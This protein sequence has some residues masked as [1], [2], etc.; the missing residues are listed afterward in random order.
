M[1]MIPGLRVPPELQIGSPEVLEEYVRARIAQLISTFS[2]SLQLHSPAITQ[3]LIAKSLG[4]ALSAIPPPVYDI[5]P[6]ENRDLQLVF[7]HDCMALG[8]LDPQCSL[9]QHNPSRRCVVNFDRKYL[10]HDMLKARCGASIRI[11][12]IDRNTGLPI[13]EDIPDLRLETYILDGNLYDNKFLEGG[14]RVTEGGTESVED[15]EMC[16]LLLNKKKSTPLLICG[17]GGTNDHQGKV[18][19]PMSRGRVNL[20]EMHV[21]DSSEAILSGRKPPFRLLVR[22]LLPIDRPQ[23][24]I[25]H[26]I[27]EGFV[28]ATRR[29]RTAGKVDIPS[30]ED[31]VSKLEHMGKE[32]VKK[33]ADI[34]AA[35][36]QVG[37]EIDIPENCIQRVGDFKLLALRA[38]QDGHLRQRLQHVL[39][40]SREKWEEARDHAMRAVVG[41]G[42]MRAWY[43]DR[44]SMDA[45]LLF[46]CRLGS[47]E[48]DRPVALLQTIDDEGEA[49]VEATL[50][51]NLTP[52]QR[53]LVRQMQPEAAQGWWMPGHPGWAI[54]P[55]ESESF[56]QT[57]SVIPILSLSD[58]GSPNSLLRAPSPSNPSTVMPRH[59]IYSSGSPPEFRPPSANGIAAGG[60]MMMSGGGGGGGGGGGFEGGGPRSSGSS[61]AAAAGGQQYGNNGMASFGGPFAGGAGFVGQQ[62][63]GSVAARLMQ[64]QGA[65][66]PRQALGT[67][68]SPG[69][70]PNNRA[71][72]LG[73]VEGRPVLVAAAARQHSAVPAMAYP[74]GM[75]PGQQIGGRQ[76]SSA[77]AGL[78]PLVGPAF[79]GSQVNQG[80]QDATGKALNPFGDF[81]QGPGGN[82]QAQ[83]Q[84]LQQQQ[85]HR[86][87]T[88]PSALHNP[89]SAYNNGVPRSGLG[90]MF[91]NQQQQ[92]R[93]SSTG[94]S[95]GSTSY[96][97]SSQGGA[98][99]SQHQQLNSKRPLEPTDSGQFAENARRDLTVP[100]SMALTRQPQPQ[101]QQQLSN[102]YAEQSQ[103]YTQQTQQYTQQN[104]HPAT[105][106]FAA[107]AAVAAAAH[108]STSDSPPSPESSDPNPFL[109]IQ[110]RALSAQQQQR[111]GTAAAATVPDQGPTAPSLDLGSLVS[112]SL[113]PNLFSS[114][115]SLGL[116]MRP[117]KGNMTAEAEKQQQQQQQQVSLQ[118]QKHQQQQQGHG[119]AD[120]T[121]TSNGG[122]HHGGGM[123][124]KS[125]NSLA[126][127]FP[128]SGELEGLDQMDINNSLQFTGSLLQGMLSS[129]NLNA[130]MQ[131]ATLQL[132]AGN[133][134]QQQQ[135]VQ[136][137][138]GQGH[139]PAAMA[140]AAASD[141]VSVQPAAPTGSG[142]TSGSAA[143]QKLQGRN[144]ALDSMQSIEQALSDVQHHG[145]GGHSQPEQRGT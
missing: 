86:R 45:G 35:A 112:V 87:A 88:E 84:Y 107:A 82:P 130:A 19:V 32:T 72:G 8:C 6:L 29:T 104:Q 33:L 63:N 144:S 95:P 75:V 96:P 85:Q 24:Q 37:I 93:P 125:L 43:A 4:E 120:V 55:M 54:F 140:A 11:E 73:A 70:L 126:L 127:S 94:P 114:E 18:I 25:R 134:Q 53:E 111:V 100:P 121:L 81:A 7:R 13:E 123:D 23:L 109:Y 139:G 46:T 57:G 14:S 1:A 60:M 77:A 41:D 12:L 106:G 108:L 66:S 102:S 79:T 76:A 28:V 74:V 42:R 2:R 122:G 105:A 80:Y 89:G 71:S 38:E 113:D 69:L 5:I 90:H 118:Q 51:A 92:K 64:Q 117:P 9:C 67:F 20:P 59:S 15:L 128:M 49:R 16:A 65:G 27:S 145:G 52:V 78:P 30:I 124:L 17:S 58:V 142:G 44:R 40:L 91:G 110:H 56:L 135:Q 50:M 61:G 31:H 10:V 48:L 137:A 3:D 138:S 22:A 129:H 47:V 21:S 68:S 97:F 39:K 26:A 132:G 131:A 141:G 103:Q 34:H 115:P 116:G 119:R 99:P 83:M 133:Q 62:G 136:E 143:S 36:A 98:A 101:Q